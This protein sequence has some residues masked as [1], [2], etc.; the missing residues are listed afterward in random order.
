MIGNIPFRG[1]SV[2]ISHLVPVGIML[3]GCRIVEQDLRNGGLV[4]AF[5]I[6][7]PVS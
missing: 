3:R 2:E 1:I 4:D 6:L 5:Q 7:L